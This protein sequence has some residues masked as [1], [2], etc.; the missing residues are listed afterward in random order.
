MARESDFRTDQN[1][2]EHIAEALQLQAQY[3]FDYAKRH[4]HLLGI[5][6][7]LA[8]RMLAMRYDRRARPCALCRKAGT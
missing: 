4:L 6:T 1:T 2:A 7:Q 3:G 8:L 5:E